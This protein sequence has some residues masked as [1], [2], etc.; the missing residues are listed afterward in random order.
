M[1][2]FFEKLTGSGA[3][4][5]ADGDVAAAAG[6]FAE[7]EGHFAHALS[8]S[9]SILNSERRTEICLQLAES[10]RKQ[11][12]FEEAEQTIRAAISRATEPDRSAYLMAVGEILVEGGKVDA[13]ATAFQEGVASAV[14]SKRPDLV[15]IAN[16]RRRLGAAM[17]QCGRREQ[18]L[19]ELEAALKAHE[20][21]YGESHVETGNIYRAHENH[22]EAQRC[23][24]E[25]L[26]VHS[27]CCGRQSAEAIRDLYALASSLAETGELPRALA[28]CEKALTMREQLVGGNFEDLAEMQFALAAM[29]IDGG[30]I[31]RARELLM[32]AIGYFRRVG[33][34][35]YASALEAVGELEAACGNLDRAVKAMSQSIG[36]WQTEDPEKPELAAFVQRRDVLAGQLKRMENATQR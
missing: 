18:G 7:A 12:K 32:Q 15:F 6:N 5:R 19:A 1:R 35:R 26:K 23:Y 16:S 36:L 14:G 34:K 13:A 27:K 28:E 24:T 3:R 9:N 25:A 2:K 30:N 8:R 4:S 10:Q 29:Y 20:E 11:G 21:A 31:G 22:P 17:L 33:G